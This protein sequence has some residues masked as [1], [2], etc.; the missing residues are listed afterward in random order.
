MGRHPGEILRDEFMV[1]LALNANR[2]ASG[3]G[4]NRSTV[5]RLLSGKQRLTPEL[6][7]R[8][9]AFFQVPAR[10]WL[11]MQA[12]FDSWLSENDPALVADVAPMQLDHDVLLTPTGVL[13]LAAAP[14]AV[15]KPVSL[16]VHEAGRTD[17]SVNG[18]R[19]VREVRF[20]NGSVALI[21]ADS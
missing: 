4:V 5:G 21:G 2:L 11:L 15:A 9:G 18:K 20:E 14:T 19:S 7:A 13:R 17:E 6:A 1:P 8:L 3:L 10:W 16:K 12:E